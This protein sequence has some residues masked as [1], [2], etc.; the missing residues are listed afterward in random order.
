MDRAGELLLIN[1]IMEMRHMSN[2]NK[3]ERRAIELSEKS[4]VVA[5]LGEPFE[6]LILTRA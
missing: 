2:P 3:K 5:R 4:V 6:V 1:A